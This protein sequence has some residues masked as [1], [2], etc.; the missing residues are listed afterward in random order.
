ME[1]RAEMQ[2]HLETM[3]AAYIELGFP[4]IEAVS[5]ALEQFGSEQSVGQ[6]WRQ[7]CD[8]V[9]VEAGRGTFW[10]A[11]RPVAGYSAVN[12]MALPVTIE[13]YAA[14]TNGYYRT[15]R[16]LPGLLTAAAF[17]VFCGE[18]ALFP[19]FLGFLAGSR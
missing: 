8:T 19:A 9:Q 4:E 5:L 12:W 7:E 6:A 16:A 13:I 15:G 2:S 17:L 18:Y 10:S 3:A 1:Q 11:I 14:I